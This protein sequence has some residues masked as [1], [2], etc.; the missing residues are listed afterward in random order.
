MKIINLTDHLAVSAQPTPADM[1]TLAA[2]GYQTVI[3][4]RPDGE[5][6]GQPTMADMEAAATA[7]GLRFVR[8]P[9]NATTFPGA[10]P[11]DMAAEFDN[12]E[13][14]LAYCRTGTRCTNLW[15]VTRSEEQRGEAEAKALALGF[16]LSLA[17]QAR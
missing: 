15:V 7:A 8:Y 12:Q 3:C 10:A 16:E 13:K 5:T 1:A 6:D 11:A 2:D 9:V 4:N 14:T 17:N